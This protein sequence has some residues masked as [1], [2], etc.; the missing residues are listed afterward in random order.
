MW[1]LILH[2]MADAIKKAN[3]L[4]KSQQV[5]LSGPVFDVGMVVSPLA[6]GQTAASQPQIRPVGPN[7]LQILP[8]P[9]PPKPPIHFLT[10]PVALAE[11]SVY[12]TAGNQP[13]SLGGCKPGWSKEVR[14]INLNS[15]QGSSDSTVIHVIDL[16]HE[17]EP[18]DEG[19]EKDTVQPMDIAGPSCGLV[20]AAS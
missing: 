18:A 11:A 7:T 5:Q 10:P 13:G 17:A 8:P 1:Q 6:S 15:N 2:A 20:L 12:F 4:Q 9:L 3:G 16:D 14:A 19:K